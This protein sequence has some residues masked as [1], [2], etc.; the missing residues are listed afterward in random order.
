MKYFKV[1]GKNLAIEKLAHAMLEVRNVNGEYVKTIQPYTSM[2]KIID[3][4]KSAWK[5]NFEIHFI[6]YAYGDIGNICEIFDGKQ[7]LFAPNVKS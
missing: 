7:S 1:T 3:E 2:G 6:T 4:V 5:S